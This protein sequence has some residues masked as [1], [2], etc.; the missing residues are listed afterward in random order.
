MKKI[1][2]ALILAVTVV[3]IVPGCYKVATVEI[4]N[5]AAVTKTVSISKDLVPVFT[6]NCSLSGCHTSGGHIPDLSP[7]NAYNSLIKGNYTDNSTPSNSKLYL[8]LTGNED[9]QMPMGAANDPSNINGLVLA[10]ITQGSKN[11]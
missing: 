11:N 2:A 4:D 6:K 1:L 7:A 9:I 8:W 10:W 3:V 5:T